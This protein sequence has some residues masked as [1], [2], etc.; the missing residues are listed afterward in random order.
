M[1]SKK[2]KNMS[3][4]QE[5]VSDAAFKAWPISSDFNFLCKD[6]LVTAATCK[7]YCPLVVNPTITNYYKEFHLKCGRVPRSVFTLVRFRVKTSHFSYYF[8][9][10]SPLSKVIVFFSVTFYRMMKYFWSAF[11][12]VATIILFFMDPVNGCSKSKLLW[13]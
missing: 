6:S 7:Y 3:L 9:M 13:K 4:K 2:C 12:T 8:E 11:Q 1:F 10:L 5:I